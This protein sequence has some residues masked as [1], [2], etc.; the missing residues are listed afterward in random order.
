MESLCNMN[1]GSKS[2]ALNTFWAFLFVITLNSCSKDVHDHPE[3]V[4]G[5][6]LFNYHCSGCHKETGK[7]NFLKGIPEN[8]DTHLSTFQIAHQVKKGGESGSKMPTFTKMS[9]EES[10]KIAAYVKSL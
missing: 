6:Q 1:K 5:E 8:R 4:T 10:I 7:G 9:D 3:L 2:T